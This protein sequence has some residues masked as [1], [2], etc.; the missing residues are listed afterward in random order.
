M[1]SQQGSPVHA[2]TNLID[3]TRNPNLVFPVKRQ[4][5]QSERMNYPKACDRNN[6]SAQAASASDSDRNSS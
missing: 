4:K 3:L 1:R 6:L 2:H 5:S